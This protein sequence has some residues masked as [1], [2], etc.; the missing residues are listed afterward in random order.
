MNFDYFLSVLGLVLVLEGLP[1]AAFPETM[2]KWL[3]AI[4]GIPDHFLRLAGFLALWAGMTLLFF[5]RS[6]F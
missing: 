1:Y 4:S 5:V 6:R 3:A 2:K